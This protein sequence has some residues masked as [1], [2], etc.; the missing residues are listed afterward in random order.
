[1]D[2]VRLK[3]LYRFYEKMNSA[4]EVIGREVYERKIAPWCDY[5]IILFFPTK[6]IDF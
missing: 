5:A 4:S 1:M 6:Y 2:T 3:A